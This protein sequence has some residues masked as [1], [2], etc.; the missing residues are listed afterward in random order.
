MQISYRTAWLPKNGCAI[1]E[2]EDA[3]SPLQAT[4]DA[5]K[6]FRCAVADG[7]TETSFSGLWAKILCDGYVSGQTCMATLQNQW[8]EQVST[9]NL[10]WYAEQ[11]LESGAYAAFVFLS[12][13]QEGAHISWTAEAIGDCCLF[14]VQDG[15]LVKSFPIET[16]QDFNNSPLL[17]ASRADRNEEALAAVKNAGGKCKAGDLFYLMSDAI[18]NWFL[19]KHA[20]DGDAVEALTKVKE[21]SALEELCAKQRTLKDSDGRALMPNDDVTVVQIAITSC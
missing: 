10:P 14:H 5:G 21:Q 3:F 2:Y 20:E 15:K 16:W 12:L 8:L 1:D 11:K 13:R 9:L 4:A 17:M 6:E 19:R 7:A 18:S